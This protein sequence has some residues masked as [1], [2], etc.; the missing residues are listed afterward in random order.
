MRI[1]QAELDLVRDRMPNRWSLVRDREEF[2]GDLSTNARALLKDLLQ[3]TM[4]T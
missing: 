3:G 1:V 4:E 2:W